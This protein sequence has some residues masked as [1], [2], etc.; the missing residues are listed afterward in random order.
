M[1][2]IDEREILKA[3]EEKTN[4]NKKEQGEHRLKNVKQVGARGVSFEK[5][6]NFYQNNFKFCTVKKN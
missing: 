3:T 4:K 1:K 6:F 2:T 5:C